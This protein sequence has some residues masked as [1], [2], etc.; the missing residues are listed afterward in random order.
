MRTNEIKTIFEYNFWAFDRVW[1]CIS[2]ISDDQFVEEIDYSTGSIRDIVVHMMS[3][4]RRW[5]GRLQGTEVPPHLA[6]EDFDTLSKTKTKWDELRK[7]FLSYADSVSQKQL[8]DMVHW[9]LP[10]RELKLDSPRWEILLHLA[11]HATDYRAQ[12]LAILHHHFHVKTVEQDM[13]LYL[14]EQK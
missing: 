7:E 2:Q 6:F 5:V 9:E 11:N 13:I 3:A 1:K 12:I 4:T 10:A 8:D 14:A